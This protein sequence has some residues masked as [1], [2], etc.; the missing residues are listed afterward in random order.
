MS[1][2]VALA[3]PAGGRRRL[4]A[5][6]VSLRRIPPAVSAAP[7]VSAVSCSALLTGAG[8]GTLR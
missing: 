2:D 1:M 6:S 8:K 7:A 4:G 3:V 5:G